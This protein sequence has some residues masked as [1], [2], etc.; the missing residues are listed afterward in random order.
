MVKKGSRWP[1]LSGV[2]GL[3][4]VAFLLSVFIGSG[5][6]IYG[7]SIHAQIAV[8]PNQAAPGSTVLVTGFG[9]PSNSKVDVFFQNRANGVV[10]AKTTTGGFF[11]VALKL[12]SRYFSGKTSIYAVAENVSLKTNLSIRQPALQFINKRS[13]L[14]GTGFLP[15]QR[16][17]VMLN[18][19]GFAST[20]VASGTTDD[21]GKL[22]LSVALPQLPMVQNSTLTVTD[23]ASQQ[24]FSVRVHFSPQLTLNTVAAAAGSSVTLRGTGYKSR[25]LVNISFQG[26]LIKKVT[27]D[28]NGAFAS[29]M[30]IPTWA[31]IRSF[32]QNVSAYGNSS[33]ASSSY[34]LQVLPT[35]T[36]STYN[37]T[38]GQYVDINGTQFSPNQGVTAILYQPQSGRS[39][40]GVV[41]GSFRA[42]GNGELSTSFAIPD[43]IAGRKVYTILFI[44]E[45]TGVSIPRYFSVH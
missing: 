13:R 18:A 5:G 41:L 43:N 19:D 7:T 26:R 33:R 29:T 30:S 1:F 15:N 12:P 21:Q 9:Y 8:S 23:S 17:S 35:A 34:S 31:T 39:S 24:N 42:A 38:L 37:G 10:T 2:A 3:L 22:D 20:N 11:N 25:E 32:Y 28:K 45:A 14:D 4:V 16:V 36:L 40:V 6:K 44:D 27:A